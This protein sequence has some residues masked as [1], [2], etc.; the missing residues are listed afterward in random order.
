MSLRMTQQ[1]A[2]AM[3]G[4][5]SMVIGADAGPVSQLIVI[6]PGA[7]TPPEQ[8]IDEGSYQQL[9]PPE[10]PSDVIVPEIEPGY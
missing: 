10:E 9:A 7:V 5:G 8:I 6:E 3:A 2:L 4:A 1:A